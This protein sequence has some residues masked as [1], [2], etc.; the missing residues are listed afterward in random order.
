MIVKNAICVLPTSPRE[1]GQWW[2]DF[3]VKTVYPLSTIS[4]QLNDSS[5][6]QGSKRP[7]YDV[8]VAYPRYIEESGPLNVHGEKSL[9]LKYILFIFGNKLS[10]MSIER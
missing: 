8:R 1:I 2:V 4:F 7:I 3:V 6:I 9:A 5:V 10:T